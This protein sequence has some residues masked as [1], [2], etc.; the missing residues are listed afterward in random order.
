MVMVMV[1]R[2]MLV[3]LQVC[4]ATA[5]GGGDDDDTMTT[6]MMRCCWMQQMIC[7]LQL[8]L[9]LKMKTFTPVSNGPKAT[10]PTAITHPARLSYTYTSI[11]RG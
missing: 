2:G 6:M 10:N 7:M 3:G 11:H 1:M 8:L 9:M 4:D 5:V